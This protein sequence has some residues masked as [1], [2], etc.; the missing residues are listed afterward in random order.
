MYLYIIFANFFNSILI[1]LLGKYFGRQVSIFTSIITLMASLVVTFLILN[2][3]VINNNIMVID[4]YNIFIIH[5]I[6]VNISFLFDQLTVIMLF[7]IISI[8]TF[9]HIF[10]AGYMSHDPF[11]VRFY[12][13]L[14]LFTFFMIILV[15]SD[16]FIQLFIG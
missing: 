9:V 3:I 4:L 7:V 14:G 16:N 10:T 6:K 1:G 13:Y 12:T 5:D 8:S 11:I 2:E 15:T